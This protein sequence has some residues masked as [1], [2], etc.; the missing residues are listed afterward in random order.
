MTITWT[1]VNPKTYDGLVLPGGRAPEYLRCDPTVIE[2]TTCFIKCS[3]PIVA[4]CHGP[5]ILLATG[6]MTGKKIACYPTM[7]P[8]CT[9]SKAE[10]CKVPND[11]CVVD[12]PII[13]GPTWLSCPPMMTCFTEM[14]GC[15]VTPP[16]STPP[17]MTH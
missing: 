14:L 4:M 3:K 15:K 11:Q 17:T 2:W 6:L 10:F 7:M 16:P 9:L 12:G 5:Q 13:T 8:E 1:D